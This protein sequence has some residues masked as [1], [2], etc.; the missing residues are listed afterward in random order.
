MG[1]F[2]KFKNAETMGTRQYI[3]EGI[4]VFEVKR[5]EQGLSK[6]P[7]SR[8]VEKTVVEFTVVDSDTMKPGISCSLVELETLQ[9]YAGNVLS[10]VAGVLGVS[11]EELKA[12][13]D[14][15]S[16]FGGVFGT[17]Q[18][19]TGQLVRCVAQKVQTKKGTDYTAKAWAPVY[20]ED[21]HKY[22]REAP[23]GAPTK[24]A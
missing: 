13:V 20:A 3:E 19:L 15:E 24:A 11:I 10:F 4:H 7:K 17:D 14:F 22:G 16:V 1:I 9:G 5:T 6:N 8:G 23:E 12:D 21:Y 18:I 2:D